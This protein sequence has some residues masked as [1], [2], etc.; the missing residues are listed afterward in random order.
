[1]NFLL[2]SFRFFCCLRAPRTHSLPSYYLFLINWKKREVSMQMNTRMSVCLFA[3]VLYIHFVIRI[4][5]GIVVIKPFD[6]DD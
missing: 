5:F 4:H 3:Q 1:M 2:Y 6:N